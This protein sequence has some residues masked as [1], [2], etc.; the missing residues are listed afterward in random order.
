MRT[1]L[2]T[3]FHAVI[4]DGNVDP[5]ARLLAE[6]A[7]FYSDGGGKRRAAL[8]PIYGKDKIVRFLNGTITKNR[9]IFQGAEPAHIN[10]LFG[11]VVRTTEGVETMSF[12][13]SND[14]VVA[15]YVVRNPD[16]LRHLAH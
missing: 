9:E 7:V 14:H 11:F 3:A 2:L 10:G 5:V 6:D 13:I 12:E 1:K 15:I 8:N 4:A 16:K